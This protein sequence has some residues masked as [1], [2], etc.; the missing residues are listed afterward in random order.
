M[1][2]ACCQAAYRNRGDA[3]MTLLKIARLGHPVLR[4]VSEPVDNPSD[5]DVLRLVTDMIA[6]MH[7]ASGI[8][9]AAPQVYQSRRV[10][11]FHVP[12]ARRAEDDAEPPV[13]V[14]AVINPSVEPIGDD[15]ALG[16]EGC[17]SIPGLRALVPRP[18]QIRYRGL[19]LKGE[20]IDRIATG[21]HARVVQHEVDHLDGILYLDRLAD[22]RSLAFDSEWHHVVAA[23]Q[24]DTD[25]KPA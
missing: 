16:M 12:A 13:D 8:G 2:G 6:T 4:Q 9:L 5:P 17:L 15:V 14:T 3:A 11:V 20:P 1:N 7:D 21:L 10:I 18:A 24:D 19:S 23:H 22:T 25:S